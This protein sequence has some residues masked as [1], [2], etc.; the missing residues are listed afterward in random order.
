MA[1][2]DYEQLPQIGAP[3]L[4]D[5]MCDVQNDVSYQVTNQQLAELFLNFTI[6]NNAG[7]PNG[8]VAGLLNQICW[9]TTNLRFWICTTAGQSSSAVWTGTGVS[10]LV[11]PTQG[12]TGISNPTI[13]TLPIAQG[14]ANFNFVAL[15]NGE[16]L[17]GSTGNDPV[18]ALLTAGANIT[19]T[20]APGSVTIAATVP[21]TFTWA[22]QASSTTM[23]INHGYIVTGGS[24]V[25]LTLPA[26]AAVGSELIIV[27]QAAGGW[28]IA[29]AAG[30]TI[31]VGIAETTVGVGGSLAS[32]QIKDSINLVCTVANTTWTAVAAPQGN[33]TIV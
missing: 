13:H 26:T 28:S 27:G 25:T 21:G 10:S 23:A 6:L 31:F 22:T 15:T 33:L 4:S 12:G 3:A 7:N 2:I 8:S 32:S 20:P 11:T 30:Q 29:Q 9:D 16:V 5:L 19:I 1:T 17:I 18:P 14:A 24:L